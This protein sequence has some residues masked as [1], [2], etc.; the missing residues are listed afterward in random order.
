[1]ENKLEVTE[2]V[3]QGLLPGTDLKLPSR[4]EI[5]RRG[6][7]DIIA[8]GADEIFGNLFSVLGMTPIDQVYPLIPSEVNVLTTELLL[9]RAAQDILTGRADA[10]KKYTTDVINVTLDI[11]GK[12][13]TTESGYLYCHEYGVKLSKEVSGNKLAV[14]VDL[15]ETVLEPDQ[16]NSIINVVETVVTTS[17]PDGKTTTKQSIVREINEEA[18]ERELAK[19]NIGMEQIVKAAAPGKTRTAFYVRNSK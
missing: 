15:L 17:Y 3:Y 16:F 6:A 5:Q 18:L 14:D 10:L 1:M 2:P 7:T 13:H 12:D 8:A 9:V 11:E 19:G 4:S